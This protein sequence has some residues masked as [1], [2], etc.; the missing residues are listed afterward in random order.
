M[1]FLILLKQD[2]TGLWNMRDV[3][4]L[5]VLVDLNR[6]TIC[7]YGINCGKYFQVEVDLNLQYLKIYLKAYVPWYHQYLLFVQC[8]V[9][10][11]GP[12]HHLEWDT[13]N[14]STRQI[15]SFRF[16]NMYLKILSIDIIFLLPI[17]FMLGLT[18]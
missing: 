15:I 3:F 9:G 17:L 8:G 10:T 6:V 14:E 16:K 5:A 4:L 1:N 2:D 13:E 18:N 7:H 12:S 11:S